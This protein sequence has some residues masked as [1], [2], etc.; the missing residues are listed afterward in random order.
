MIGRQPLCLS[1]NAAFRQKGTA[2]KKIIIAIDGH[3]STGKS[4]LARALGEALG[5]K[6]ISTGDMYRAVTL[7][8]LRHGVPLDDPE[9]IR[10]AL[11]HIRLEFE[12]GPRGNRIL[13]NG[14]D[15]QDE[16][17]SMEV[18]N[19]VSDVAAIPE[20]RREMVR[21][22]RLIGKDKGVV[23]DGRDIGTVVFPEAEL[24]IF[25]TASPE[26]RARRRYDE[27]RAK[28]MDVTL[29]EVRRN[30]EAR[31]RIDSTRAD[32]PLRMADDAVLID[33]SNLTPEEQLARALALARERIE[34]C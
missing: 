14:Q 29:D 1:A 16:I 20:V 25:L 23:M 34:D 6:Y 9:A 7:Y 8:F 18:A 4:T 26:V 24:K 10:Q 3:S 31:D 5:Y 21:Q 13:M 22:Q 19:M 30:I 12:T 15:V 33:N 32:S 17:R 27:L 11:Q 28:G 2:L